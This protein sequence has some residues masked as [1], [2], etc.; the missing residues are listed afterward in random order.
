MLDEIFHFIDKEKIDLGFN[1]E[2]VMYTNLHLSEKLF[3][4]IKQRAAL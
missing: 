4:N 2:H 1:I 3:K